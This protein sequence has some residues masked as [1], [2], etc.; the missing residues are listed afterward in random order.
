MIRFDG[1][2]N[3]SLVHLF[4]EFMRLNLF[5]QSDILESSQSTYSLQLL[6]IYF[7]LYILL[8]L[9][10]TRHLIAVNSAFYNCL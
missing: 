6:L 7:I 4:S 8:H 5:S 2:I 1:Q 10:H 3:I 9:T